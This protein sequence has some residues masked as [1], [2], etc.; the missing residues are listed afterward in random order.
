MFFQE[1]PKPY[2]NHILSIAGVVDVKKVSICHSAMREV[3]L[4]IGRDGAPIGHKV[5]GLSNWERLT[6]FHVRLL[7]LITSFHLSKPSKW[8]RLLANVDSEAPF[9]VLKIF[10]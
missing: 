3:I 1:S 6:F 5:A 2:L 7:L 9:A 8:G 10:A 4:I